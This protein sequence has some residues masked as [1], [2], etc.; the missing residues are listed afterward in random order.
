MVKIAP[1]ILSA[2]FSRL[3]EE[4]KAVEKAGADWIHVDVMDG[5][6]VPNI[7]IG[8][9]VVESLRKVTDLPLDCHL[10]IENADKYIA[11]FVSAGADIISV[12]V[13]ACPHLHRTVQTIKEHGIKAGVVLNPATTLFALDEIIED[14]DMVLLM[15]V[16]PGFGGQKFIQQVL[17]K[18][19]LLR[20][21]LD[22]SDADID[23]QVD[24]G[25]N[26]ENV[27]IVKKAG[28]NVIVAGSAIFNAPDYKKA[29]DAL[30]NN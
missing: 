11:D 29:I 3:G 16:N 12:H 30:R 20:N 8:P 26:P 10:M 18:I 22:Q 23:V 13:E 9:P 21:T 19:Q 28:A 27:N 6:F 7:T 1:S 25:V 24:G 2:D 5:A 17:G 14:V 15:S 4:V